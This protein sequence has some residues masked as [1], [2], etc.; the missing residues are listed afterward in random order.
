MTIE[1][2]LWPFEKT[3]LLRWEVFY[4]IYN[5]YDQVNISAMNGY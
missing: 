1:A 3:W 4:Y 2:T 5:L